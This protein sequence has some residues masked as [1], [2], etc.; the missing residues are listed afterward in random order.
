MFQDWLAQRK[1]RSE[2]KKL[3]VEQEAGKRAYWGCLP[4]D[5]NQT[6]QWR[7]GWFLAY[8]QEKRDKSAKKKAFDDAVAKDMGRW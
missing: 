3:M 7:N 4:Y 8:H 5:E 6:V 1:V 2:H